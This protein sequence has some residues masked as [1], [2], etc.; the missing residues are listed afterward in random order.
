MQIDSMIRAVARIRAWEKGTKKGTE[1]GTMKG[2]LSMLFSKPDVDTKRHCQKEG[3]RESF[4][5]HV[6]NIKMSRALDK[7]MASSTM[8]VS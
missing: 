2:F 6:E 1:P 8:D 5:E 4:D 3:G 7:S